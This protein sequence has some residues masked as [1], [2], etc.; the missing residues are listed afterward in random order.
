M[1][2]AFLESAAQASEPL[3]TP[4]I[5]S[6][7]RKA[8]ASPEG[9]VAHSSN[10]SSFSALRGLLFQQGVLKSE[11]RDHRT[12]CQRFPRLGAFRVGAGRIRQNAGS[13]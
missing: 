9:D 8:T 11:D 10:W 13:A 5:A 4:A 2:R 6:K 1:D 7:H 12:F 3:G